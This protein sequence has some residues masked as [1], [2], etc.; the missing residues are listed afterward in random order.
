MKKA[1]FIGVLMVLCISAGAWADQ[2]PLN[3][4]TWTVEYLAEALPEDANTAP[5]WAESH[6]WGYDAPHGGAS[7]D[8]DI[9]S[10]LTDVAAGVQYWTLGP[11]NWVGDT[12]STVEFRIRVPATV[13]GESYAAQL[14]FGF[15][16][17]ANADRRWALFLGPDRMCSANDGSDPN[18]FVDLTQWHTF[19]VVLTNSTQEY[20]GGYM[21]VYDLDSD[22]SA[23]VIFDTTAEAVTSDKIL[24][25]D[26]Y[27]GSIGGM[28]DLDYIAWTNAGAF[29]PPSSQFQAM[30]PADDVT[31]T[32]Q[33]LAHNLPEDANTTPTWSESHNWG[34]DS[35]HGNATIEEAGEAL[36]MWTDGFGG[37]KIWSLGPTD[38]QGDTDSSVEFRF[39]S[40]SAVSG[41]THAA[42]LFFGFPRGAN[43]DRRWA[44]S[45][46]P[47]RISDASGANPASDYFVNLKGW[48]RFRVLLYVSTTEYP[49]GIMELYDR[50]SLNPTV[51]VM[52][53]V[54]ADAITSTQITY[55]D[56]FSGSV[57]GRAGLDYLAWTNAGAFVPSFETCKQ[58]WA[59]DLGNPADTNRD[60]YLD[61]KDFAII[62]DDWLNC[63]DPA[64][65]NNCE[66]TW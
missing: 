59:N 58:L 47:D 12:D 51:P 3:D 64:D 9:L 19:R 25:G 7:C 5:T 6:N 45:L 32:T 40:T 17:G 48:H 24:Y 16:R 35:P 13:A 66:K 28:A 22:D 4:V 44:I 14:F 33:Y 2:Q 26:G 8:G 65:P 52:V 56:L 60:C 49:G 42:Q 46:G 34:Y 39:R 11:G 23:P 55:G 43:D 29:V 54:E 38:W 57:G 15:P 21:E 1:G 18:Y 10:I 63:N 36:N 41:E 27:S 31:W 20:P 53:D 62:A 61:L 30:L 37:T 50:D